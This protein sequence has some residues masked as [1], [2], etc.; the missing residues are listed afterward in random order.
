MKKPQTLEQKRQYQKRWRAEHPDYNK[1]WRK[2][3]PK[4][5]SELKR[6]WRAKPEN[7]KLEAAWVLAR[8]PPKK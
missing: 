6:E 1:E 3:H 4:R 7:V 5:V 2:K 8:R